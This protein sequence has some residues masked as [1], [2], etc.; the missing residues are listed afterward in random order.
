[1]LATLFVYG[2]LKSGYRGRFGRDKQDRLARGS[3][4]IGAAVLAGRLYD[5]GRYPGV[6]D[7]SEPGDLVH[8]EVVELLDPQAALL[9]LD[10]YEGFVPGAPEVSEY[11]RE[12]RTVR[13]LDG[14]ERGAGCELTAWAYLYARDLVGA[15]R[16]ES[17][18]WEPQ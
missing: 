8:G 14:I 12:Q 1:M 5:L 3:R 16:L 7:A 17:G 4:L 18:R 2:T 10:A 13:L 6:I 11:L 9:W 15:R